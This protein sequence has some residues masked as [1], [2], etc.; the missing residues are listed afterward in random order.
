[1]SFKHGVGHKAEVLYER[2][3]ADANAKAAVPD[4]Y[5]RRHVDG[6]REFPAPP[7]K[8]CNALQFFRTD[9]MSKAADTALG[10]R[11]R[12]FVAEQL[13]CAG[14]YLFRLVER[15]SSTHV[16][17]NQLKLLEDIGDD[18]ISTDATSTWLFFW[19]IQC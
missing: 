8:L 13:Y 6:D 4:C 7:K 11:S 10:D 2:F 5:V 1:M 18:G 14:L 17:R 19:S 9:K 15:Q 3:V 12:S 16:S